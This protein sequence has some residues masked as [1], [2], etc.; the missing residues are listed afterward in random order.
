[1]TQR[2]F[3]AAIVAL[4]LLFVASEWWQ[5]PASQS[6]W[7]KAQLATLRSLWIGSLPTPPP[8]PGN[9][10]S[11]DARAVELGRKLF[12]DPR[13][14]ANGQVA[15]GTCHQPIRN[16]TDGLA[17]ALAIG[18]SARNTRS[19][20]AAAFSPWQYADGRKDSLWSQALAPLED[21]AEHGGTRMQYARFIYGDA[22]YRATYEDIFGELPDLADSSRF[23]AG[24][25]PSADPA[26]LAAWTRMASADQRAINMA[27]ANIGKAIAAFERTLL[28][29]PARFD[30]YVEALLAGDERAARSIFNADEVAG[31]RLFIGKGRCTECHN[32]PLFSNNEFH[33]TGVLNHPGDLPDRGRSAGLRSLR[34]DEFNCLGDYSDDPEPA[35]AELRFARDDKTL[36][37]A[38]RTPSLRNVADTAP[39]MHKGQLNS[40][41]EVIDHY[42]QARPALIG[43]NEA[44]PLNLSRREGRQLEA[45]LKTLS[46]PLPG[47]AS[48]DP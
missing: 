22:Q 4:V 30:N 13:M 29:Q 16:F 23:P 40:L 38:F 20:V 1:M 6:A 9:A 42:R 12:F 26:Q 18:Q 47:L 11:G 14:S 21:P 5:R 3:A 34:S 39:Y 19:I 45:F 15:C 25:A 2:F 7:S 33:N 37:G 31:L 41:T 46:G 48:K 17:K 27:F 36:L 10:V 28:P 8:D 24:A 32:G 35:C 44:K 43:H